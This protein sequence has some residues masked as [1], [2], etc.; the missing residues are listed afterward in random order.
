MRERTICTVYVSW[1]GF[2]VGASV[3]VKEEELQGS[4]HYLHSCT[5]THISKGCTGYW[6]RIMFSFASLYIRSEVCYRTAAPDLV[7]PL[8]HF[9]ITDSLSFSRTL[10]WGRYLVCNEVFW[11][12][13]RH[14]THN[15]TLSPKI[16]WDQKALSACKPKET[17][18]SAFTW[19]TC[20]ISHHGMMDD[21]CIGTLPIAVLLRSS[22]LT[23]LDTLSNFRKQQSAELFT[24]LY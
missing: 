22:I 16:T 17:L 15:A 10:Q 21:V 6:N 20:F 2:I 14:F 19:Q 12:E 23:N 8:Y 11:L 5:P 13:H 7:W 18:H 1:R 24:Y 9:Y 4:W 3:L